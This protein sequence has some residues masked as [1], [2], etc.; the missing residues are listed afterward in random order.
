ME[1]WRQP[2]L[3]RNLTNSAAKFAYRVPSTAQTYAGVFLVFAGGGAHRP[4]DGDT[5]TIGGIQYTWRL[6]LSGNAPNEVLI[7]NTP[8]V[9][10]A[11]ANLLAALTND[12]GTQKNAGVLYDRNTESNPVVGTQSYTSLV[13]LG[14][15][16]DIYL[17][18]LVIQAPL[19]GVAYNGVAV[20]ASGQSGTFLYDTNSLTHTTTT[21]TGG[22]NPSLKNGITDPVSWL[23]FL[24]PDTNVVRSQVLNDQFQRYYFAS[25]TQ[26]P[27][28]N[29]AAR[30]AAGQPAFKLGIN[31]PSVAPVIS[32]AGG[33][34]IVLAPL[35]GSTGFNISDYIQ[36]G[37]VGNAMILLPITP[38]VNG[39]LQS[40]SFMPASTDA[41]S[42]QYQA[43]VYSDAGTSSGG[44][45]P[46]TPST[47]IAAGAI[48]ATVTGSV[49]A[50]SPLLNPIGL[51]ANTVYWI[52]VMLLDANTIACIPGTTPT[53][54]YAT[55]ITFANGAPFNA[56]NPMT[57]TSA[58][59]YPGS[60]MQPA[61][62]AT[63]QTSDVLEARA[64][65]YTWVSAYNEESAPSPFA[66]AN[67]FTDAT[68]QIQ[69]T[70]P[71]AADMGTDRNLTTV[72]L[73]RTVTGSSGATVFFW[74]GDFPITQTAY[75]DT[76]TDAVIATH[77][78]LPSTTFFPPPGNLQGIIS[79]PNGMIAGFIGNQIWFCVPFL[80][81]AWPPGDVLNTEFPIVGLGYTN[82]ALVVCTQATPY[83][84]TGTNPST[85][86]V[87]KCHA[88]E[89]CL[90]RGSILSTDLGV[91]YMSPNGLIQVTNLAQATNVT[92]LWITREKWVALTPQQRARTV[93]ISGCYF[94][95]GTTS[96]PNAD[97]TIAVL[98]HFDGVN[99][100]A[101]VTDAASPRV[102]TA[103]GHAV[104]STAQ[105]KFGYSSLY[106]PDAADG[107]DY[108]DTPA[109]SDL[110]FTTSD[111]TVDVWFN[112]QGGN[113]TTRVI[114]GQCN[115]GGSDQSF[116]LTLNSSNV[117]TASVNG[118]TPVTGTTAITS[119]GWHHAAFIRTGN[120]LR[121]FL[122][123]V[124]EG[125]DV[126]FSGTVNSSASPLAIGRIG[127]FPT[128]SFNGYIDEFRL[129][130]GVARWTSNF[131][132]PNS[133]Y[134]L[135]SVVDPIAQ[136]GFA[137]ELNQDNTSFTIWPQP[138]GH[139]VGFTKL[140][141]PNGF[142]VDNI[143]IDPWTGIALIIQNGQVYYYDFT[144]TSPVMQPYAYQ[145]KV[146][147]QNTKKSY[148]AMRA[149]FSVPD[150]TPSK[151]PTVNQL[152]ETD[153]SWQTL[154][155]GQ[156]GIILVYCDVT[157]DAGDG[158][159][160]LVCARELR[161]S[162]ELLRITG[163][164]KAERWQF[165]VLGRIVITNIQVATSVKELA[166]V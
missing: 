37:G 56:P 145:S 154:G 76:Q 67:G 128:L 53:S 112:R 127:A 144:D 6:A 74:V 4:G 114:A 41:G 33:N 19:V 153:P 163:G 82:G 120:I 40:I 108:V 151:A 10:N 132:P 94:C 86:S 156:W 93:P 17:A 45:T 123:G 29:T 165:K 21:F 39:T 141:S 92:E 109:S 24:D 129:S 2:K 102:W 47:L 166:N 90:S 9:S 138:G 23:E 119:I 95:Y 155:S 136:Q 103:H 51:S 79:L 55:G 15:P 58:T 125:G 72:R 137:L 68:W 16:G 54:K 64:Y 97:P 26:Q 110:N 157:D 60:S 25:P 11:A 104:L 164:Y 83:V 12:N 135:P 13:P 77:I 149:F 85:M 14:P 99:N 35:G 118:A 146:Y 134:S 44:T 116:Q 130:I 61:I 71:P 78:Q 152:P 34:N 38:T 43:V 161:Q 96:G 101:I 50:V 70:P 48:Q 46:T 87:T 18:C 111:F 20:S 81:H 59:G 148:S 115:S 147:Q 32:V 63:L 28:Y 31:P 3:L 8:V 49:A 159:M 142:N 124:Q 66:L 158:K 62:W 22:A 36:L 133:P 121:L 162:G 150:S 140:A 131:T 105:T 30:I 143:S 27:Q 1:G 57:N 73:Y 126:A 91:Y 98:L 117:L 84:L 106:C 69:C 107:T 7:G 88:A 89:P 75:L 100:S 113:G 80:P 160:Q 139:R 122:D 52:G 5:V 42:P 65:V